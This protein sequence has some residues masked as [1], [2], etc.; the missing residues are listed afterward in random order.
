MT[1]SLTDKVYLKNGAI[2]P[3]RI[4]QAPMCSYS[5]EDYGYVSQDTYNYY[6]VRS[7]SAGMII[8]EFT[9]VSENG[10][11]CVSL[12]HAD[13]L[14]IYSPDHLQGF[15]QLAQTLK[16]H[17]NKVLL[18]IHH[19]GRRA[20]KRAARGQQSIAPSAIDSISNSY[21]AR[22]MTSEE[23]H[24]VIEDFG[25]ASRFAVDCGFD[26]VEIHGANN[27]LLQQFFSAYS[28]RRTDEWGGSLKK[29]MA[30]PIAVTRQVIN[31]LQDYAPTDFIVGYRLSPE[32]IHENSFGYSYKESLELVKI[33]DH[34]FDLDY[35]H[36]SQYAS[37]GKKAF[38]NTPHDASESR[39][40]AQIFQSVLQEKTRLIVVGNISNESDAQAALEF[41]DFAAVGHGILIDPQF[42]LKIIEGRGNEIITEITEEQLKYA[43]L[44]PGL[45]KIFSAPPSKGS[46][47][48]LKGWQNI[49]HLQRE[50]K[51][52]MS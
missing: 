41:S 24:Q 47:A 13:Q 49:Q 48:P 30:F 17:G 50:N 2:I 15:K 45:L 29:R 3:N 6:K 44:T 26:G 21:S 40:I 51:E 46:M 31:Q 1:K 27:Y 33:L 18:Q 39:T 8:V 22:E 10:G 52:A 23:I 14:A 38:Q 5:G 37:K 20:S 28:N 35:F 36:L 25:R 34:N 12:D 19:G 9:A 4:V 32:E 7:Q 11:P 43:Q 42:G 16:R